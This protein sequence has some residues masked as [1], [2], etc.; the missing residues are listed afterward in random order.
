MIQTKIKISAKELDEFI[1]QGKEKLYNREQL[2]ELLT[3]GCKSLL[4]LL[5]S[6]ILIDYNKY[7]E[8]KYCFDLFDKTK[9]DDKDSYIVFKDDIGQYEISKRDYYGLKG[10]IYAAFP[11]Y[12]KKALEYFKKC[13]IYEAKKEG[14]KDKLNL[15]SF[16]NFNE[17]TLSDLINE[18]VTTCNPHKMNDP[19]DT[20]FYHWLEYRIDK[21]YSQNKDAAELY[22]ESSKYYRIRSF[23]EQSKDVYPWQ[24]TLMWSHYADNHKGICVEYSFSEKFLFQQCN[25]ELVCFN[26]ICY[27][28][29]I[30]DLTK[31]EDANGYRMLFTKSVDW[32]YENECRLLSYNPEIEGDFYSIPLDKDSTIKAVYFGLRCQEQTIETVKNILREEK[33]ITFYKMKKNPK[34]IYKLECYKI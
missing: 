15:Y 30:C 28:D 20:L 32:K 17:H 27:E 29:A 7:D 5:A 21:G 31:D 13:N 34:N 33:D 12:H 14:V 2:Y 26:R 25:E 19:F 6:Y 23:S 3:N 10:Q 24:N 11:K 18:T 8:A 16:R 22:R 9:S 4:Y 1:N